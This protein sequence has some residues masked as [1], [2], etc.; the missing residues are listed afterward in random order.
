MDSFDRDYYRINTTE[1]ED[2]VYVTFDV[3]GFSRKELRVSVV[4]DSLF[5]E[6]SRVANANRSIKLDAIVPKNTDSNSATS[7]VRSGLLTVKFPKI[8][9]KPKR[10]EI[11]I[12]DD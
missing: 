7:S 1:D 2:N 4:D 5:V 8:K 6:G 3:P 10:V 11:N 9:S 12:Y